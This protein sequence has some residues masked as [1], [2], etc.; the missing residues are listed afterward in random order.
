MFGYFIPP[1]NGNYVFFVGS[2]DQS[3][4]YLSTDDQPANKKLIARE[5]QWSN[6][7]QFT[8]SG[9]NSDLTQKRSDQNWEI[10]W[11]NFNTITLTANRRYYMEVLWDEGGGGDGADVTFIREGDPDPSNDAAGMRMRGSVIATFLD[12]E[13]GGGQHPRATR[14]R[15]A[16]GGT[17]SH[18]QRDHLRDLPVRHHRQLSVAENDTRRQH[19][20]RHR[21][22][23]RG[24]LHHTRPRFGGQ[25]HQVP[26]RL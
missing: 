15:H 20:H 19:L 14:Q 5:T 22:G 7:Y 18:L 16:T 24:I 4:V 25:Q 12:P 10:E 6:Q 9:G 23:H 1:A 11:P 8:T 17:H 21:R 13:R 26:G 2:D 3:V